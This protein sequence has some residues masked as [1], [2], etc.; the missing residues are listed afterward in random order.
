MWKPPQNTMAEAGDHSLHTVLGKF[1]WRRR[2]PRNARGRGRPLRHVTR[3]G[4]VVWG[5]PGAL[6]GF[7][8]PGPALAYA[9][10]RSDTLGQEL[11]AALVDHHAPL[12]G[13]ELPGEQS[14]RTKA[15]LQVL[16]KLMTRAGLDPTMSVGG[17]ALEDVVAAT[18]A[19]GAVAQR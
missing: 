19:L 10:L 14:G 9:A 18:W 11:I 1:P 17:H 4:Q 2:K 7:E 16:Q 12:C 13:V 15:G 6:V 8:D 3:G 5:D